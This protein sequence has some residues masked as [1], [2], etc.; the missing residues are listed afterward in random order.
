M[1]EFLP[2]NLQKFSEELAALLTVSF[3]NYTVIYIVLI[4]DTSLRNR[5]LIMEVDTKLHL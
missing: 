1:R 2:E 3:G 5:E 4:I